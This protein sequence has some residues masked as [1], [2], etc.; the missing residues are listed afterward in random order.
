MWVAL[1]LA[2]T[3]VSCEKPET[4]NPDGPPKKVNRTM[5]MYMVADNNL[6][7]DLIGD[8]NEMEQGFKDGT[9]GTLLVYLYPTAG[10]KAPKGNPRIYKIQHDEDPVVIKSK[11]LKEY[12][13]RHDPLDPAVMRSVI[14]EAMS[15][16][17]AN[18]YAIGFSSH[19]TGWVPASTKLS[20]PQEMITSWANFG[21][22]LP[23]TRTYGQIYTHKTQMEIYDMAAK[24]LP[25]DTKFDFIFFD[26]CLMGGVEVAYQ[27]RNNTNYMLFSSTEVLSTGFPYPKMVP[28]MFEPQANV[29]AMAEAFAEHYGSQVGMLQSG[30]VSVVETAKLEVVAQAT[31]KVVQSNTTPKIDVDRVFYFTGNLYSPLW[32]DLEDYIVK[33]WADSPDLPQFRQALRDAVAYQWASSNFFDIPIMAHCGMTSFIP[34]DRYKDIAPV[35][36][37]KYDWSKDSGLD[38]VTRNTL[39]LK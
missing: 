39:D 38:V 3:L 5:I 28:L 35:Y 14:E 18:S 9:D 16:A 27:L 10:D 19:S 25:T 33:I 11:V 12:T 34:Q 2:T 29:V 1:L 17:P 21:R 20:T 32:F 7:R 30:T 22:Q 36:N 24:A 6:Y 31:K 4:N 37:E 15:L 8:I 26:A 13:D 23:A